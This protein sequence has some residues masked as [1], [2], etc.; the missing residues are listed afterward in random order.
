MFDHAVSD[1][2][3]TQYSDLVIFFAA[4]MLSTKCVFSRDSG[5]KVGTFELLFLSY[6]LVGYV[7]YYYYYLNVR[8]YNVGQL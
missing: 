3:N 1:Q 6:M 5:R 2:H 7:L 4:R 8:L